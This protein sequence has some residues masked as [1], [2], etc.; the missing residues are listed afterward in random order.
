MGTYCRQAFHVPCATLQNTNTFWHRE[1]KLLLEPIFIHTY[2]MLHRWILFWYNP[3]W[4]VKIPSICVP[5]GGYFFFCS[6][7]A[8]FILSLS[9]FPY[10]GFSFGL[11]TTTITITLSETFETGPISWCVKSFGNYFI[12]DLPKILIHSG[13]HIVWSSCWFPWFNHRI[14][15]WWGRN[16]IL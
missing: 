2:M 14:H 15:F 10:I 8:S 1:L 3:L 5:R 6:F 16:F 13:C 12:L 11:L 4:C 7:C 9:V